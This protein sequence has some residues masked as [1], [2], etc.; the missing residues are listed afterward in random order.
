MDERVFLAV[1]GLVVL[2]VLIVVGFMRYRKRADVE[3]SICDWFKFRF[4]GSNQG[5]GDSP[6]PGTR[7]EPGSQV[8]AEEFVGRDKITHVHAPASEVTPPAGVPELTLRL[9]TTA[10]RRAPT[11]E[12]VFDQ[13]GGWQPWSRVFGLEL[14]NTA[15]S[16]LARGIDIHL[17]LYWGGGAQLRSS[18]QLAAP[19]RWPGWTTDEP[20][21]VHEH[22]AVLTFSD[23][24]FQ[25]FYGQPRKWKGFKLTLSERWN[26]YL[27]LHY[28]VSSADPLTHNTG[29]LRITVGD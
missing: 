5:D 20:Q 11:D 25:C 28:R 16:T 12:L 24:N 7:L 3:I 26:G 23:A 27:E 19:P 8:V 18:V 29:V 22:P 21:L 6:E 13:T 9:F 4:A 10:P 1:A 14:R 2:V 17:W 15:E